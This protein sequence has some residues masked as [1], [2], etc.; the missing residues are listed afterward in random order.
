MSKELVYVAV[1]PD[2]YQAQIIAD[3][4]RS[5]GYQVELLSADIEG[6]APNLGWA[7]SHRLLVFAEDADAVRAI[8]DDCLRGRDR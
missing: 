1:G 3:A 5:E 8:V 7:E 6:I 4:C 2:R